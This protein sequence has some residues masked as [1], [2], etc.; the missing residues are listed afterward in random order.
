[1]NGAGVFQVCK[2]VTVGA[3]LKKLNK[4][5]CS[6]SNRGFGL[7]VRGPHGIFPEN[8]QAFDYQLNPE[9]LS[10]SDVLLERSSPARQQIG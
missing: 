2:Q 7:S 3:N 9:L 6:S 4:S 5:F 10:R 1:M 8:V